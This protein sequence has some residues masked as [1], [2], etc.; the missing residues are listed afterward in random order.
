MGRNGSALIHERN[1]TAVEQRL[2][3]D[4]RTLYIR[5]HE[6][7]GMTCREIAAAMGI[8]TKTLRKWRRWYKIPVLRHSPVPLRGVDLSWS[9]ESKAR[10][11]GFESLAAY[12]ATMYQRGLTMKEREKILDCGKCS[13]YRALR[14]QGLEPLPPLRT[15]AQRKARS[16]HMKKINAQGKRGVGFGRM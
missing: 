13:I 12:N 8:A 9:L 16:E 15:E 14:A 4:L 3:A 11:M 7:D 6:I 5:M 2:G 10:A 1:I